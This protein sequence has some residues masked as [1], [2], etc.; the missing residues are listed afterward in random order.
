MRYVLTALLAITLIGCAGSRL[1]SK[2]ADYIETHDLN[3]EVERAIS[4]GQVV[5]GMS[6]DA[7]VAS[8]GRYDRYNDSVTGQR[9][10]V[11]LVYNPAPRVQAFVYLDGSGRVTAYQNICQL[12]YSCRK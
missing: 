2:R 12:P 7:V 3:P 4:D 11:Q 5:E 1:E 6:H 10:Q 8:L 9:R